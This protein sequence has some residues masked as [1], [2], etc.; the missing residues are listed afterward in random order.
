MCKRLI[1]RPYVDRLYGE[2]KSGGKGL[3]IVE[4][5]ARIEKTL[6]STKRLRFLLKEQEQLLTKALIEGVISDDEKPKGK[7]H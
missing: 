3:I 1:R 5:C 6:G 7:Q 2:R 4:K